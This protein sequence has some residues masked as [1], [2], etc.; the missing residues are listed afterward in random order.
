MDLRGH[1]SP[2][3]C[4]LWQCEFSSEGL[5]K[6]L[7]GARQL[8]QLG[9]L[10]LHVLELLPEPHVLLLLHHQL[11]LHRLLLVLPLGAAG[12]AR[13]I[14]QLAHPPV[15]QSLELLLRHSHPRVP[16]WDGWDVV[17]P[18]P[19]WTTGLLLHGCLLNRSDGWFPRT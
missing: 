10:L 12:L 3:L 13:L 9:V 11:L 15:L 6:S 18:L 2:D 19:L 16:G 7:V 5:S 17:R 1:I 4:D 14:V 8:F